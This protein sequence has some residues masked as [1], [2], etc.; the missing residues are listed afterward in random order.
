[1]SMQFTMGTGGVPAGTYAARFAGIEPYLEN[2][3]KYGPGVSLKFVVIGGDHDGAEASRICSQKLSPKSALAKL[4]VAIKGAPIAPGESFSFDQYV[5]VL[6]TIVVE[7]TDS[8]STRVSAFFRSPVAA[9][10]Q[11]QSVQF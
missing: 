7:E 10:V 11:P 6:G 5:G 3:E 2:Q 8:G 1:M 4:A 9:A